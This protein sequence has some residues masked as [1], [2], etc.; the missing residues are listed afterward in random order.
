MSVFDDMTDLL[1]DGVMGAF[2]E[3]AGVT[4]TPSGGAG[5]TVRAIFDAEALVAEA[6]GEFGVSTYKP[7]FSFQR[8]EF[9][10]AGL[11]APEQGDRVT[12]TAGPLAGAVYE[13]VEP[14]HDGRS[15]YRAIMRRIS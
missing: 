12:L 2:E 10:A 9:V 13:V 14:Q 4:F 1:Q 15:E 5:V 11:A 6:G 7:M 3:S 8:S